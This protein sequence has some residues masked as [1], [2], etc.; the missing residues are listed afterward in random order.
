MII[1]PNKS[2]NNLI[3]SI[4]AY[5]QKSYNNGDIW[6]DI[7]NDKEVILNNSPTLVDY[8]NTKGISLDGVDDFIKFNEDFDINTLNSKFTIEF[9]VRWEQGTNCARLLDTSCGTYIRICTSSGR[10]SIDF[11]IF[12]SNLGI[13]VISESRWDIDDFLWF[14]SIAVDRQQG[15]GEYYFRF[16]EN[17]NLNNDG[18]YTSTFTPG[19]LHSQSHNLTLGSDV[20][21]SLFTKPTFFTFNIYDEK[22][23][24]DE[25]VQNY[26]SQKTRF[27]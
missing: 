9:W 3:F 5:N 11:R 13:G 1:G 4:D 26:E 21:N 8:K 15:T 20:G 27:E 18:I 24:L 17:N 16:L 14:C 2:T 7:L 19:G 23:S 25:M 6:Y 22:I 10:P 12:G